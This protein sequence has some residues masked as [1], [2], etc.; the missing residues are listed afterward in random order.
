MHFAVVKINTLLAD[1]IYSLRERKISMKTLWAKMQF[2]A[3]AA[4]LRGRNFIKN[5]FQAQ[6]RQHFALWRGSFLPFQS[7]YQAQG[8][9]QNHQP[10][11]FGE[12]RLRLWSH[13]G[14]SI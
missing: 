1:F 6:T 2:S 8:G 9:W 12:V 13:V 3:P 4:V 10:S 11:Q 14:V 5:P 7:L